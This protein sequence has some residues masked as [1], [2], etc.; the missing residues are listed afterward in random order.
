M[1]DVG[2]YSRELGTRLRE[3]RRKA[4]LSLADVQAKTGGRVSAEAVGS[5]ERSE[6]QVSL[7]KFIALAVLYGVSP[8]DLVP[9]IPGLKRRAFL[10]PTCSTPRLA[11]V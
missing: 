11:A 9:G 2:Q 1:M 3:A 5:Y 7:E 10:C 6:R 8:A 4:G